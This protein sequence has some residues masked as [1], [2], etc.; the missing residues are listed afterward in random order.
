[1]WKKILGIGL[2]I[3]VSLSTSTA[4]VLAETLNITDDVAN[5]EVTN[6]EN[7]DD[8]IT[9]EETT[10]EWS[11]DTSYNMMR[12]NNLNYGN[13]KIQKLSSTKIAING[14]TQCHRE[15]AKVYLYIYLER[16]VKGSY[17][18]YKYWKF[19][20]SNVSNLTKVLTVVV[21][22]GTY[23]RVRGYH[24][25]SNGGVKESTSTLTQGIKVS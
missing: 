15:C 3:A 19:D 18:T 5:R 4:P 9:D 12:S 10:E 14:M 20:A 8:E 22:S 13:M 17:G 25:A 6:D 2:A 11:E 21:P 23:Y 16:K 7:D 1:M 24:A